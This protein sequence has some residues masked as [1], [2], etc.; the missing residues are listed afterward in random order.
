MENAFAII[1][2]EVVRANDYDSP[3]A[4]LYAHRVLKGPDQRW[5]EVGTNGNDSCANV[6]TQ[7]GQRQRVLL[8]TGPHGLWDYMLTVDQRYVD[9]IL[10]SDRRR[11]FP[12]FSGP[13]P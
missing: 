5:F 2:A 12:Y 6:F 9:R 1:D 3:P 11:D 8:F 13:R 10:G 7:V 4:L